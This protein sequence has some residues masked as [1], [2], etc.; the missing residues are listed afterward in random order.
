MNN[1]NYVKELRG[2]KHSHSYDVHSNDIS[3]HHKSRPKDWKHHD[4]GYHH[5]SDIHNYGK[6]LKLP[7]EGDEMFPSYSYLNGPQVISPQSTWKHDVPSVSYSYG[8]S[9]AG[10]F[11][12]IF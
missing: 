1:Y 6:F 7:Y 2:S 3:G 10:I 12:Y 9:R 4:Y 8:S 5:R 11:Y